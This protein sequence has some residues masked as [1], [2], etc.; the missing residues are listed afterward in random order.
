MPSSGE[1]TEKISKVV[2]EHIIE[3]VEAMSHAF[4]DI[5]PGV[6]AVAASA[7]PDMRLDLEIFHLSR[8]L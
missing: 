4:Y 2:F 8:G 3:Q 5:V 1:L 6:D 7:A